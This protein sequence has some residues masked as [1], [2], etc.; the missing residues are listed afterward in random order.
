MKN[1]TIVSAISTLTIIASGVLAQEAE[2]KQETWTDRD[3]LFIAPAM[4]QIAP[5]SGFTP[6]LSWIGE[7]WDNVSGGSKTGSVYDSLFTLGLEQDLSK[8]GKADSKWGSLGITAFWYAQS[9]RLDDWQGR[10]VGNAGQTASNIFSSDMVRVFEIYYKNE[11]ETEYGTFGFRVGQ[12][13]ADEDFMG[14]DY[15]DLFLN[16]NLGAI[17]TNACME[18][19]DG[20]FAF[21]QYSLA[22]LGATVYWSNDKLDAIVGFYNGNAGKDSVDNHGFDYNLH[23]IAVWYQVG[24]NYK[25]LGLNGRVQFGG[26]YHSGD[27]ENKYD[28]S[29]VSDFY[30]FYI[31]V[32]QDLIADSEGNAILGGFVR[33]AYTP[34]EEISGCDKYIDCGLNWFGPLPN[35]K[36]DIL[37]VVFSAMKIGEDNYEYDNLIELTYR[38]QLTPAIA[39]Q[40][41]FQTYLNAKDETGDT[42][43]AY[44][45]GVRAEVNF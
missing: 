34:K 12:L 42:N 35:R 36:D 11:F 23:D 16:A 29:L 18:L 6:S 5:D 45:V 20:S 25:L 15:S 7:A 27:F 9:K 3:S 33:M 41:V 1:K 39:I 24:M 31:G 13:A 44:V 28:G 32:Q 4:E 19:T 43:V 8:L 40:P 30:S 22:T 17:P 37:G 26:N 21:S 10:Y 38:A 14:M 2:K